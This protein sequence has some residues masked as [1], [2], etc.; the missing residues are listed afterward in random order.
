[1]TGYEAANATLNFLG[2]ETSAHKDIIPI[3]EDEPHIIVARRAY[4]ALERVKSAL[5]PFSDFFM[6]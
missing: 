1:M 4:K 2:Y 5:N 6:I 3:E